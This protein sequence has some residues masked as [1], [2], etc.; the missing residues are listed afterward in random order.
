MGKL[1]IVEDDPSLLAALKELL[2]ISGHQVVEASSGHLALEALN[3]FPPDLIISDV[4]MPG[5]T[6]LQLLDI[7]RTDPNWDQIPFLFVS[8]SITAESEEEIALMP[9]VYY[10]R[11][12]FDIDVLLRTVETA[13]AS[14]PA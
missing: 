10:V 14:G 7:V 3:Y 6:G 1:L 8:A 4:L 12:P 11:K 2:S 13:L 5:M 9:R